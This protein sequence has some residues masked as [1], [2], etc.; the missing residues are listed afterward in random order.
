VASGLFFVIKIAISAVVIVAV[1]EVAKRSS[2][3]GAL[4]ASPPLT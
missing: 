3:F 1:S 2:L 4:I